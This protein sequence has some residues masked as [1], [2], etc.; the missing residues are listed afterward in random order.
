MPP[1]SKMTNATTAAGDITLGAVTGGG[2]GRELLL[3]AGIG[4][5]DIKV[6]IRIECGHRVVFRMRLGR[7]GEEK[8][9]QEKYAGEKEELFLVRHFLLLLTSDE[10]RQGD[11]VAAKRPEIVGA[12]LN[13]RQ[14]WDALLKNLS[15]S[16]FHGVR[17]V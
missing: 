1:R 4:T 14:K 11:P 7:R 10:G 17:E 13:G 2:K 6:G 15:S 9:Q 3:G 12:L 8:G 16:R 5:R